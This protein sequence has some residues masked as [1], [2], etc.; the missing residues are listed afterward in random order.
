VRRTTRLQ[1]LLLGGSR[2]GRRRQQVAELGQ[3]RR[4]EAAST[5]QLLGS[6]LPARPYRPPRLACDL[7]R[8]SPLGA[9]FKGV[10]RHHH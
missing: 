7:N 6:L 10:K 4:E 5:G 9:I 3:L 8:Q 1:L 2:S